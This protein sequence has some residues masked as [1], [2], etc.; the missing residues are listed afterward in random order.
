VAILYAGSVLACRLC[1]RLA[2]PSQREAPYS[3][4]LRR[5]RAIRASLG[6]PASLLRDFPSRPKGMHRRTY[7]GLRKKAHRAERQAW[8]PWLLKSLFA[9]VQGPRAPKPRRKGRADA[10]PAHGRRPHAAFSR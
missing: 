10:R 8:P 5:M 1:Y 3:R 6:G 7:G 4:A 9:G 2:Y